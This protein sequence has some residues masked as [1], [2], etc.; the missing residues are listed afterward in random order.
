MAWNLDGDRPIY[1][2]LVEILQ[3]KIIAGEYQPGEKLPSVR[4]F[5]ADAGVNPNTMQRAFANLEQMGLIATMRTNGRTVA[6]NPGIISQTGKEVADAEVE[7]FF[8]RMKELG[9]SRAKALEL[10]SAK[11]NGGDNDE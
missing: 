2:Q 6:D 4:E 11:V 9:Y 10:A 1:I 8:S 7:Q 3:N 5:A